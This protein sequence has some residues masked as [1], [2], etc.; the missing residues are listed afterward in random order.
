MHWCSRRVPSWRRYR[1]TA[2]SK[3]SKVR[4]LNLDSPIG[5]GCKGPRIL[6]AQLS[7]WKR[8]LASGTGPGDRCNCQWDRTT[9]VASHG[10]NL[11]VHRAGRVH[12]R[13]GCSPLVAREGP[14]AFR[15]I[16]VAQITRSVAVGWMARVSG[17]VAPSQTER[18]IGAVV[19]QDSPSPRLH[20]HHPSAPPHDSNIRARQTEPQ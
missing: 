18:V 4:G 7:Q 3:D 19:T 8:S 20:S 14:M 17:P 11:R 1:A 2:N 12:T 6:Y 15:E 10:T 13:L 9:L 16:S 5:S